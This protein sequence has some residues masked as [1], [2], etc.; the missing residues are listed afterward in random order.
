MALVRYE[1]WGIGQLQSEINRVFRSFGDLDSS[2]ATAGWVPPVDIY[3]HG[4]R[5]ELYMD[6]PGVEPSSLE[7]TLEGGVLTVSGE[8]M[9]FSGPRDTNDQGELMRS[10]RGHGRFYRRFVLPDTVDSDRVKATNRNGVLELT[11]PKQAKALPRRIQVA[12]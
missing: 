1:P 9:H 7:I 4:D 8:R 11:I 2:G 12:A 5:F 10:E 6:L 3:E